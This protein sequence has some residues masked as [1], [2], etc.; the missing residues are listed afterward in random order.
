[1]EEEKLNRVLTAFSRVKKGIQETAERGYYQYRLDK[2]EDGDE[3]CNLIANKLVKDGFI[4]IRNYTGG[5]MLIMWD[6]NRS[7]SPI[8]ERMM[9]TTENAFSQIDR[10]RYLLSKKKEEFE[11]RAMEALMKEEW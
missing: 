2:T 9:K 5:S 8:V 7:K 11:K 6:S 4:V 3:I 10:E 1:M